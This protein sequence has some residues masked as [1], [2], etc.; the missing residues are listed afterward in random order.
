MYRQQRLVKAFHEAFDIVVNDSPVDLDENTKQ[1]R[2]S[3][4]GEEFQELINA[5]NVN[6]II[7]IADGLADLLYVV[8]GTAVSYG[9]D[10]EA[11][12]E[13]V[14]KSNMTKI[15]GYKRTDGKW[16][17]PGTYIPPNLKPILEAQASKA[18]MK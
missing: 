5:M 2:V 6:N 1:L 14:H 9:I 7:E 4:I 15:G 3:L 11:I 17:K 18:W 10:L 16:I 8:Y 12:F 13:E